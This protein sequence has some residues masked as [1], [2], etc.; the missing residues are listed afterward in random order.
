MRRLVAIAFVALN[1]CSAMAADLPGTAP[2]VLAASPPA[3]N[4]SGF[5]V[6]AVAGGGVLQ[7]SWSNAVYGNYSGTNSGDGE[8]VGGTLGWNWQNKS[9]VLGIEGD[10]SWA[11]LK[12]SNIANCTID[13]STK[14]NWYDTLRGRIGY[15]FANS[16]V[17]VYVTGGPAFGGLTHNVI[18]VPN[19]SVKDSETGYV[20]G[21]GFEGMITQ[22]WSAKIEYLVGQFGRELAC[23]A[24]PCT[25]DNYANWVRTDLVRG[26]I[27]YHF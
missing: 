9:F 16:A 18:S 1:V 17:M 20:F 21:A 23:P 25:Y 19:S 24:G 3:W 15:T 2:P 22:H 11:N 8:L 14:L 5:Y 12:A 13:C 26:G 6:G 27:N 4:W 10:L 7:T